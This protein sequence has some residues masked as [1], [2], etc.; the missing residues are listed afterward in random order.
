MEFGCSNY[1]GDFPGFRCRT[2]KN[3]LNIN[4]R[5]SLFFGIACEVH[6]SAP[7]VSKP[8]ISQEAG[9]TYGNHI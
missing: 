2:A 4:I 3:T 9:A 1:F 7:E 5:R 6:N 8:P